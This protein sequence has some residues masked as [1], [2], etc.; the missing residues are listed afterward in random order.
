MDGKSLKVLID[1][2]FIVDTD[3]GLLKFIR[4]KYSKE[5]KLF[6]FDK[7][8]I[9]KSDR[10]FLSLLYF[11]KNWNPLSIIS[12]N[13]NSVE[14]DNMYDTLFKEYEEDILRRSISNK[15]IY[16]FIYTA[17]NTKNNGIQPHVCSRTELEHSTLSKA[18]KH[19]KYIP[20]TDK[21]TIKSMDLFYV[22]DYRFFTENDL[23]V[24]HKNIYCI[25][26]KYN[27]DYFENTSSVLTRTNQI[28]NISTLHKE[29]KQN[30]RNTNTEQS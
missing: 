25:D 23:I 30:G 20:Y 29:N 26:S 19:I 5:D 24:N 9:N 17:I 28:V 11:R 10:E 8:K 16:A 18:F 22:K 2:D 14:L 13:T 6:K 12:D 27:T 1:F 15:R 21:N 4:D 3:I 7:D